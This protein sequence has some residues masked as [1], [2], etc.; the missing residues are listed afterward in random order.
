MPLEFYSLRLY[1]VNCDIPQGR[2]DGDIALTSF[3]KI[4]PFSNIR[5]PAKRF[6]MMRVPMP[7]PSLE[8]S[9]ALLSGI[10]SPF[11]VAPLFLA[12]RGVPFSMLV[13]FALTDPQ[14]AF[15]P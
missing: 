5:I 6:R 3:H 2:R 9:R 1:R 10:R 13:A 14:Y 4:Q 12:A 11:F 8:K 15:G 7:L